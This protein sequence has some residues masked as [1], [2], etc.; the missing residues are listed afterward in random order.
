LREQAL[1]EHPGAG[2][3]QSAV[4]PTSI[5]PGVLFDLVLVPGPG[6]ELKTRHVFVATPAGETEFV[7]SASADEFETN[8]IVFM[9]TVRSFRMDAIK[10]ALP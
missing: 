9:G 3:L 8:K 7:L 5:Q 2:I 4:C 10:P 6:V 1:A